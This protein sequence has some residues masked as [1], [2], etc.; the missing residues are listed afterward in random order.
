MRDVLIAPSSRIEPHRT[1]MD[2]VDRFFA[3]LMELSLAEWFA[4]ATA[5]TSLGDSMVRAL[6]EAVSM[7]ETLFAAWLVRDRVSTAWHRF[8]S[9]AGRRLCPRSRAHDVRA[10]TERAAQALLVRS[11]LANDDFRALYGDFARSL[12]V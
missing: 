10:A 11:R 8:E 5:P 6:M 12:P 1:P 2:E 3:R 9:P 7:P 4:S